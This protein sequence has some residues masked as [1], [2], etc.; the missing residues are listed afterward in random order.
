MM[1]RDYVLGQLIN[2]L[3][4]AHRDDKPT[5]SYC[6][7]V[8]GA[9]GAYLGETLDAI[10]LLDAVIYRRDCVELH[11]PATGGSPIIETRDIG[12]ISWRTI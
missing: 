9:N 8:K 11:N 12:S 1:S 6:V 2:L 4:V 3:E 10:S 7:K 5:G